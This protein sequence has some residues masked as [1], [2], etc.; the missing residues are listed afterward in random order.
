[1]HGAVG[2]GL[3]KVELRHGERSDTVRNDV[4]VGRSG[5]RTSISYHTHLLREVPGPGI[6]LGK[7]FG[8]VENVLKGGRQ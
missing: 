8:E 1:M 7:E 4:G 3:L 6:T 2:S 5:G